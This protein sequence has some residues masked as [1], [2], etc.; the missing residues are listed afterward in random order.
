ML[1]LPTPTRPG[2]RRQA[3]AR[4]RTGP[5]R[6]QGRRW[7][8]R[9]PAGQ[10]SRSAAHR[11]DTEAD[12][13][14]GHLPF[15]RALSPADRRAGFHGAPLPLLVGQE[16]GGDG[17]TPLD[18]PPGPSCSPGRAALPLPLPTPPWPQPRR[19]AHAHASPAA[20][21]SRPSLRL[22]LHRPPARIL[23]GRCPGR[24]EHGAE[25][26]EGEADLRAPLARLSLAAGAPGLWRRAGGPKGSPGVPAAGPAGRIVTVPGGRFGGGRH[27]AAL[28]PCVHSKARKLPAGSGHRGW[29]EALSFLSTRITTFALGNPRIVQPPKPS[30]KRKKKKKEFR[31]FPVG[32]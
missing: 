21:A 23:P 5:A 9:Q 22:P 1:L 4:R 14:A 20:P 26:A 29:A 31:N 7:R 10:P 12:S 8:Q 32:V 28:L 17:P 16:A 11:H 30:G 2:S 27:G 18:P 3:P 15:P 13:P 6:G 19:A 24:G 25:Q